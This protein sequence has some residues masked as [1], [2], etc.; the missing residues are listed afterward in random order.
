MQEITGKALFFVLVIGAIVVMGPKI[1]D[2]VTTYTNDAG[3][4]ISSTMNS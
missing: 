2:M 4:T 1:F 3:N